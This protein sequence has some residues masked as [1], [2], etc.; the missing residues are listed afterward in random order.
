MDKIAGSI[1]EG[2]G[3]SG[4]SLNEPDAEIT[5]ELFIEEWLGAE[6]VLKEYM[7]TQ[8]SIASVM[9]VPR[10]SL[11]ILYRDGF[12]AFKVED[13]ARA[14]SIFMTLFLLDMKDPSFHNALGAAYEA[15]E[16]FENALSMYALS[17]MLKGRREPGLL[18]RCGKCLLASGRRD[19][20]V[21][22]FGLAAE[23]DM[24]SSDNGT[25]LES[26]AYIEKSKNMLNLLNS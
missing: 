2:K 6:S 24:G 9:E 17:M 22:V 13:Y 23:F 14:E 1:N 19:E 10:E 11:E 3:V 21:I 5:K 16:K 20:A 15:Q 8:D 18:F 7:E 26:V 12:N 25:N 4:S